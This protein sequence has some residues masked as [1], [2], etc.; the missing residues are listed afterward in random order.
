MEYITF[1]EQVYVCN[2]ILS[3]MVL[4]NKNSTAGEFQVVICSKTL[5][6]DII[7]HYDTIITQLRNRC[8]SFTRM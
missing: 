3:Y 8:E 2:W 1:Y 5:N 4:V 6:K 7:S